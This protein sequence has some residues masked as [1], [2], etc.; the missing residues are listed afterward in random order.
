MTLLAQLA[1]KANIALPPVG[2]DFS[3]PVDFIYAHDRNTFKIIDELSRLGVGDSAQQ[4]LPLAGKTLFFMDHYSPAPTAEATKLHAQ[5]REVCGRM[6]GRLFDEGS[7]VGHQ[8]ALE[9]LVQPGQI[10][11]GVDSH[12]CTVGAIGALGLRMPAVG[13]A[14]ALATGEVLI[15]RPRTLRIEMTGRLQRP[16]TGKDVALSIARLK[17]ER[18][19]D[20]ILEVGGDGLTSLGLADRISIS[21][22]ATD[23]QARSIIFE[24]DDLIIKLYSLENRDILRCGASEYTDIIPV[25]LGTIEPQIC[26]PGSLS[27]SVAYSGVKNPRRVDVVMIGSCTN[28][29]IED[30]QM[31]CDTLGE[32]SIAPGVRVIATPTSRAVLQRMSAEGVLGHLIR[33]G[34]TINPPGCGP[35][36]GLHQG[37]LGEGEVCVATGSRNNP[38]RMGSPQANV[39]LASPYVA[40]LCAATGYIGKWEN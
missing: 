29:Q 7:G 23:L 38:G 8:L 12:T 15:Y 5:Q 39:Y 31:F 19:A 26:L 30:F 25:D 16:A 28:G 11:V 32:N 1:A 17:R 10:V 34:V 4:S 9:G 22:L 33:L 35:C 21:N 3:L 27:N 37:L 24:I 6:G 20:A 40:A 13:V 14:R 18:F 2:D 36:M